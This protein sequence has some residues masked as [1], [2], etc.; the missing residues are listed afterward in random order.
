MSRGSVLGIAAAGV[1]VA[2]A[3]LVIGGAIAGPTG[4]ADAGC[5]E[6]LA[7]LVAIRG[8]LGRGE[9]RGL[10]RDKGRRDRKRRPAVRAADF[11]GYGVIAAQIPWAR[12]SR[13]H[14]DH[15]LARR[16]ARLAA[17]KGIAAA[18]LDAAAG[19]LPLPGDA[20]APGSGPDLAA[21]DRLLRRLEEQ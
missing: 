12:V 1:V 20:D 8:W 9:S 13:R 16:L 7:G 19:P 11:P 3:L 17:G 14:Y 18:D 5:A 4:I 21:I 10:V 15:G 6:A 2:A